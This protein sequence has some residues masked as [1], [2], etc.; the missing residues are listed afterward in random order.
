MKK[1]TINPITK[2]KRLMPASVDA[3]KNAQKGRKIFDR[4]KMDDASFVFFVPNF[5]G[6]NWENL[7]LAP[8]FCS[9]TFSEGIPG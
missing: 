2:L 9:G 8:L 6:K 4:G 1:Y 7:I 5:F 3:R